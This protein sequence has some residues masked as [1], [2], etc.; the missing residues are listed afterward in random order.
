ML[1]Y[2]IRRLLLI[3]PTLFGI[4]VVNFIVVQVLRGG[5]VEQVMAELTGQGFGATSRVSTQTGAVWAGD[6]RPRPATTPPAPNAAPRGTPE[7]TRGGTEGGSSIELE[8]AADPLHKYNI[9]KV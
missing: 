1:A 4:M 6:G 8:W 3:I 9:N 5:P 7:E 2:I